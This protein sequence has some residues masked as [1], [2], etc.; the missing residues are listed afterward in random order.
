VLGFTRV[1][2]APTERPTW[3]VV[4]RIVPPGRWARYPRRQPDVPGH[5]HQLPRQLLALPVP[6]AEGTLRPSQPR[7]W[8]GANPA[9]LRCV[10]HGERSPWD[11]HRALTGV[12]ALAHRHF[13]LWGVL[14]TDLRGNHCCLKNGHDA[15]SC[16]NG[17]LVRK[18][19]SVIVECGTKPGGGCRA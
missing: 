5:A 18:Y 7:R 4:L 15:D 3:P 19:G 8:H 14:T 16:R 9:G 13:R 17:Y 6:Q 11:T 2:C 12:T 1:S 10:S